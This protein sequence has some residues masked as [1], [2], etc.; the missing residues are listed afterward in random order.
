M[1]NL[2]DTCYSCIYF[3]DK[4]VITYNGF[5]VNNFQM[6][7]RCAKSDI[8]VDEYHICELYKGENE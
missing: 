1:G 5:D 2:S 7:G 4:R 8:E 3:T 6:C